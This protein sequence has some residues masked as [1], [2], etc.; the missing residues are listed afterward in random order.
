MK[1]RLLIITIS[2]IIVLAVSSYYFLNEG[3][4]TLIV[5]SA[6]AYA[7]ESSYM[8]S[9]FSSLH[10]LAF[11]NPKTGGSFTLAR[12]IAQGSPDDV[13]ISVSKAAVGKNYLGNMYSGWA[14]AFA[15][16]QMA[17]AYS[18]SSP[19][20]NKLIKIYQN[21]MQTNSNSSWAQ[22]FYY[23]TSGSFKVGIS[24]PNSDPAGLRA[25]FMLEAAGLAYADNETF[26]VDRMI[27][28]NSN[29]TSSSAA[30][31][32]APLEAGQIDI[33]FIYRSAAISLGLNR[34][35]LP[36]VINLGDPRL[37]SFYS[38][39]TWRTDT[40]L[41]RGAPILLFIT[42]PNGSRNYM[43]AIDFVSYVVNQNSALSRFGLQSLD[44]CIAFNSSDLPAQL[45]SLVLS[46]KVSLGG[47][48]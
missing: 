40:G 1:A 24:D 33:L 29:V 7:V 43:L 32:V 12:Q 9:N 23:L 13:F 34:F 25:W 8:L 30:Q 38:D 37:S 3:K 22:F 4:S 18:N 42:V 31:L 6:D 48:L 35:D 41:Q 19:A 15:S 21:A 26:Y 28:S 20:V 45:N 36:A 11:T 27:G 16:D 14:I 2:I 17:I 5:Y 44:P 39:L 46:G 47:S 10:G